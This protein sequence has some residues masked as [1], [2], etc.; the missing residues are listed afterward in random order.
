MCI[1]SGNEPGR[2][3]MFCFNAVIF[4]YPIP[5]HKICNILRYNFYNES[6]RIQFQTYPAR[7]CQQTCKT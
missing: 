5:L 3:N 7:S 2:S 1:F 6:N 4:Q